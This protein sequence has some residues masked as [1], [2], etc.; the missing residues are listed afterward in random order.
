[1][2]I[3]T[4]NKQQITIT[5]DIEVAQKLQEFCK[6]D[7]RSVSSFINKILKRYFEQRK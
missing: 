5:L 3:L 6:E 2:A 1:M 7:S 4:K